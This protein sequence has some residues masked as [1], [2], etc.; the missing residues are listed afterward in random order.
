MTICALVFALLVFQ[1]LPDLAP[2]ASVEGMVL[3]LG[4]NEPIAGAYVEL[5]KVEVFAAAPST[6]PPPPIDSKA[7]PSIF[8]TT[9]ADDGRFILRDLPAGRYRLVATR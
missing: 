6:T 4:T 7:P 8:K 5:S 1:G 9:T 3:K 2:S